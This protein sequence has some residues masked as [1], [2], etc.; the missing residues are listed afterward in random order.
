MKQVKTLDSTPTKCVK[1]IW[2]GNSK[3]QSQYNEICLH[4][5]L[6]EV[7]EIACTP[8]RVLMNDIRFVYF[9]WYDDFNDDLQDIDVSLLLHTCHSMGLDLTDLFKVASDISEESLEKA[10]NRVIVF[11]Y[12]KLRKV[13]KVN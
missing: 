8:E 9:T 10:M 6:D 4:L 7:Q 12:Q 5:K 2:D 1:R 13:L 3:L 11:V